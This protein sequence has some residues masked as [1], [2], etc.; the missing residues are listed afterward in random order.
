[1]N[2]PVVRCPVCSQTVIWDTG[3]RFRPFCSERCKLLDLGQW[4]KE[5]YAIPDT[6]LQDETEN[7]Q[8]DPEQSG[9]HAS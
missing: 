3:N 7:S 8:N 9:K 2:K 6:T 1:M 5:S 4:A